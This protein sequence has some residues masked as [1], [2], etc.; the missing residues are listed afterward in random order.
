MRPGEG[1]SKDADYRLFLCPAFGQSVTDTPGISHTHTTLPRLSIV[2][3]TVQDRQPNGS[4]RL[5]ESEMGL[6]LS[7]RASRG[8][9][10]GEML[11]WLQA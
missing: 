2:S 7:A 9:Q 10:Q 3:G 11:I 8:E 5:G 4:H 6:M 1:D